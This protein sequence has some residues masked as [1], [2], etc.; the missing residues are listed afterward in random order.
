MTSLPKQ[1][2]HKPYKVVTKVNELLLQNGEGWNIDKLN[3]VFNEEDVA[4]ILRVPVG[5]V[6]TKDYVA[7]NYTKNG[8]FL[9]KSAYHLKQQLIR[10][11]NG[12][13]SSSSIVDEHKVWLSIWAI[14]VPGKVKVHC[15]RMVQNRLAL[16]AELDQRRFKGVCCVACHRDETLVHRV[17]DCAHVTR[18]CQVLRS[19]T[20]WR[21][22]AP[23]G[24]F[25]HHCVW[26]GWLLDWLSSLEDKE[27][28]LILMV[29][30]HMWL[31][32]NNPQD[33]PMIEDPYKIARR[34]MVLTEE[35]YELKDSGPVCV[36]QAV[37]H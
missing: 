30:Y 1:Y 37:E 27:I 17:W 29:L 11:R 15:W 2:G 16:G 28:S 33:L 35:W 25:R 34:V 36:V 31:A 5:R 8:I 19:Q 32:R 9:V 18:V 23:S 20:G 3:E 14:N 4:D 21:M 6:G 22:R 10:A 13:R 7:W 24:P 12:M 26:K